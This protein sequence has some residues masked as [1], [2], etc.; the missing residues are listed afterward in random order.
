MTDLQILSVI[1]A[2][3]RGKSWNEI[4]NTFIDTSGQQLRRIIK[5]KL[6]PTMQQR[7]RK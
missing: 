1:I 7:R 2:R 4:A 6:F 5:K 3:M